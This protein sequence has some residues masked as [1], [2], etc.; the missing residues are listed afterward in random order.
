MKCKTQAESTSF[1]SGGV[2]SCL[3]AVAIVP[4]R[5]DRQARRVHRPLFL[6]YQP[7]HPRSRTSSAATLAS[8]SSPY[9]VPVRTLIQCAATSSPFR[10]VGSN[11]VNELAARHHEVP[12]M[13]GSNDHHGHR[14]APHL[15]SQRP[16]ACRCKIRGV[17]I[18]V[19]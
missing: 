14:L 11:I 1:E 3:K 2:N 15:L 5:T 9:L 12:F 4:L 13:Q 19:F 18:K 10:H 7:I 17:A 8:P 6:R 16:R